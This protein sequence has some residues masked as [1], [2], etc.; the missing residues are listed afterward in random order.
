[1]VEQTITYSDFERIDMRVGKIIEAMDFP[2][3]RKPA[4]KLKIDFGSEIGVK[5]S[6]AQLTKRYRKEDLID[7]RIIAVVNFATKQ[8]ANFVSEV[9]VLGVADVEGGI[10]LLAT[11]N[12]DG[13]PLGSRVY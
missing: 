1:L 11:E 5:N 13:A 3:A 7:R 2:E 10:C 6:S 4:Y 9:L 8:I 12:Q